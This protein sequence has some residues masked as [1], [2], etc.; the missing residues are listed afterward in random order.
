MPAIAEVNYPQFQ[1]SRRGNPFFMLVENEKAFVLLKPMQGVWIKTVMAKKN[2]EN[3]VLSRD[4]IM[5]Q[6]GAIRVENIEGFE[7]NDKLD[8]IIQLL[9][10]LT[11]KLYGGEI[12]GGVQ[13]S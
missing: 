11:T 5:S 8:K 13:E 3:D 6:E 2:N 4:K 12:G 10:Q 9:E 1:A 7:T